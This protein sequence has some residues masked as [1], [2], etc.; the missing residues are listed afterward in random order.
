MAR[1]MPVIILLT[2]WFAGAAQA[3]ELMKGSG[4]G[5]CADFEKSYQRNPEQTELRYF[6]WAQG[7]MA[8]RN[9]AL[10]KTNMPYHDLNTISVSE[11]QFLIRLFCDRRPAALFVHAVEELLVRIPKTRPRTD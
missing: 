1:N 8:A 5:T 4:A 7:F 3:Q 10:L 11:Q 9:E 6:S 2:F